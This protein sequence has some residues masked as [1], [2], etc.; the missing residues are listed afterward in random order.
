MA[1]QIKISGFSPAI[2]GVLW[3]Y[4]T[5]GDL[6]AIQTIILKDASPVIS[7]PVNALFRPI[8][9]ICDYH[10]VL[11]YAEGGI[12]VFR[13]DPATEGGVVIFPPSGTIEDVRMTIGHGEYMSKIEFV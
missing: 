2:G 7:D 4:P 9:I 1:V 12:T 10:K 11:L 13:T 6:E 3:P 5:G 8:K